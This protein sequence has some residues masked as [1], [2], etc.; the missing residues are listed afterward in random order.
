LE[1]KVAFKHTHFQPHQFMFYRIRNQR[2]SFLNV[3]TESS[4][5]NRVDLQDR[6]G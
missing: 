5:S 4:L 2:N 3:P 1:S 6:K